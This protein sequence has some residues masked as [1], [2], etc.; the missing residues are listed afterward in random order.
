M[1]QER[2]RTNI[3]NFY[4]KLDAWLISALDNDSI[5]DGLYGYVRDMKM[6]TKHDLASIEREIIL[7]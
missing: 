1:T 6:E 2:T 3:E 7:G 5:S 4:Y